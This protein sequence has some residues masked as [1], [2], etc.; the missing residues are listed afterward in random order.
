MSVTLSDSERA[1]RIADLKH[2]RR[3]SPYLRVTGALVLLG[4][5]WAW[6]TSSPLLGRLPASRRWENFKNFAG[7]L[8]P[9]PVRRS[10]E[11]SDA[12]PWAWDL[13][14]DEGF[15]ALAT[16]FGIATAAIILSGTFVLPL[17]TLASRQLSRPDP[18]GVPSGI[19][20]KVSDAV[21]WAV[22][23]MTRF[24]FVL[25]RAIPEYL[26]AFL[27]LSLLGLQVWPLVL[28]LAIHNLGILGRLWGE[29][30]ENANP[31]AAEVAINGGSGRGNTF[32]TRVLPLSFNRFLIYF[33]YR[34]ETC[35]KDATVLGMLGLLTLGKL[36]ALAKGFFWDEMFFYILLGASVILLGDLFSTL[37]RKKLR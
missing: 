29:V 25:A 20:S 10:G 4:I 36:I 1:D 13:L 31:A 27:L 35:V 33:F 32:V 28:A 2:H 12:F 3:K 8:V 17:L 34:W 5:G 7:E 37:L 24:G 30:V 23:P 21:L 26:L 14:T 15:V 9:S 18:F 22:G 16:T 19:R 6:L 11:W